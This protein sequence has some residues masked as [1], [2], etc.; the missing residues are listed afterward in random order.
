[1]SEIG[2]TIF[3]IIFLLLCYGLIGLLGFKFR[4]VTMTNNRLIIIFPFRL[5][6]QRF[7]FDEI[8]ELKWTLIERIKTGNYR[9]LNIKM[10][11]GYQIGISD[12]EFVNYDRMERWLLGRTNLELDLERKLY[13]ELQQAKWN[14][15]VNVLVIVFCIFIFLIASIKHSNNITLGIQIAIV[16]IICRL[17]VRLVRY[18]K[19]ISVHNQRRIAR[20]KRIVNP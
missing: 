6:V 13:A 14:R 7:A 3:I 1:M 5:K 20:K 16:F 19:T 10:N 17:I 11:S 15:W 2:S 9:K 12:F 8:V 4:I 18:Q